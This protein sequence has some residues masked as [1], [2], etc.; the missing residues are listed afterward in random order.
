M[1]KNNKFKVIGIDRNFGYRTI[2]IIFLFTVVMFIATFFTTTLLEI[3]IIMIIF[4][5]FLIILLYV[6]YHSFQEKRF[7]IDNDGIR[8]LYKD[9]IKKEVKWKDVKKIKS[10]HP[11][12]HLYNTIIERKDGYELVLN[13]GLSDLC[14]KDVIRAFREILKY[15]SKYN[16]IV[17]DNAGWGR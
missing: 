16:F 6:S 3:I 13:T 14:S 5:I 12:K 8:Y 11:S 4:F 9:R 2:F 15:Q 17:N 10:G 7:E 1:Q